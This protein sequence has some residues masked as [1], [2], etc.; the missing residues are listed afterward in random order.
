MTNKSLINSYVAE[1]EYYEMLTRF[2]N[3]EYASK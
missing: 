1:Y 3:R 2:M